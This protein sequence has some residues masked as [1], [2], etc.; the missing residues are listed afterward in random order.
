[1]AQF[2]TNFSE[3]TTGVAPSD[4]SVTGGGGLDVLESGGYT[5][6][7]AM[8]VSTPDSVRRWI[9]ALWDDFPS[10]DAV[11]VVSKF[12]I[13]SAS[14]FG[15]GFG[16]QL[17]HQTGGTNDNYGA[18][19]V[20]FAG[21]T[22]L[23][24]Y[25]TSSS[26]G[27]IA[28]SPSGIYDTWHWSLIKASGTSI[29]A[30]YWEDGDTPKTS[31]DTPDLSGTDSQGWNSGGLGMMMDVTDSSALMIVDVVGVGTDG[32]QAP[33]S[34]LSAPSSTVTKRSTQRLLRRAL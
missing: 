11:E 10:E 31:A 26:L 33:T 29:E 24:G 15:Q 9:Q 30:W 20:D 21:A 7:K 23:L 6:G 25:G 17:R 34:P 19:V 4:W 14:A 3:Y 28:I 32:D 2:Y 16:P 13:N 22:F 1:M 27:S 5:G 12:Q 18:S 8:S